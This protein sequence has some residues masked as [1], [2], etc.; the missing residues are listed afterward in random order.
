LVNLLVG[1]GH[2]LRFSLPLPQSIPQPELLAGARGRS[3]SD[4]GSGGEGEGGVGGSAVGVGLAATATSVVTSAA[5]S[6]RRRGASLGPGPPAAERDAAAFESRG[7]AEPVQLE[8]SLTRKA[9]FPQARRQ[10]R[11]R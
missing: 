11:R 1:L 10:A 7:D 6:S 9:A 8:S 5:G 2:P 3:T 4:A